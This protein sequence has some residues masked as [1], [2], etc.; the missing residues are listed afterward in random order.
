VAV[1]GTDLHFSDGKFR[2]ETG[3]SS[4][5]GGCS[6]FET[7]SSA[8]A[9]LPDYAQ[10]GCAGKRATPDLALLSDPSRGAAVYD[11]QVDAG[12]FGWQ[13]VGGTSLATPIVA[14]RAAGTGQVVDQAY[15]YGN[16]IDFRD[17]LLGNN[18]F[19]CTKGLDLVTG[20][21]SWTG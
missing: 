1:G 14:A 21:G 7:A 18:G 19:P 2:S 13:V 5:G 3:W 6:A 4:G 10:T 11:S 15:V 16:S 20:R 9:A 17:I 8:Q 12:V